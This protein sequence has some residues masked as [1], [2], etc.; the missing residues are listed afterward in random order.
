MRA[1]VYRGPYC[2]LHT[3]FDMIVTRPLGDS[4]D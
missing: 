3:Q 4:Q 2:I 1:S